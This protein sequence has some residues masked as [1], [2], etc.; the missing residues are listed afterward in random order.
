MNVL[1]L[2]SSPCRYELSGDRITS[3]GQELG[4]GSLN[5]WDG[6]W[7][8][9]E[10]MIPQQME[11]IFHNN[12]A[13][14][15]LFD[16]DGK[17]IIPRVYDSKW[18]P[19]CMITKFLLPHYGRIEQRRWIDSDVVCV[20]LSFFHSNDR[21]LPINIRWTGELSTNEEVKW[22]NGLAFLRRPTGKL[23]N[24]WRVFLLGLHNAAASKIQTGTWG[25][26]LEIEIKSSGTVLYLFWA[27]DENIKN[28][29]NRLHDVSS[30][31]EKS[32][33]RTENKWRDFFDNNIPKIEGLPGWLTKQYYHLF[34]CHKA[35]AYPPIGNFL[36][37]PFTCPSK[38]RL[39][40]QWFWD[41]AFHSIVEKWLF[42]FPE[43]K[44]SLLN[45]LESQ[46]SDGRLPFALDAH[47]YTFDRLIGKNLIQ[48]FIMPM[49]VWDIFLME[50]DAQWLRQTLPGLVAFDRWMETHRAA[51]DGAI[52]IQTAGESG[53]DN[54]VRF[55]KSGGNRNDVTDENICGMSPIDFNTF[56][57]TGRQLIAR[58]AKFLGQNELAGEFS[59]RAERM[60]KVLK[61]FWNSRQHFFS[62]RRADDV[63]NNV[64]TPAMFIPML[65]G[66]AD[67][68]QAR[69][70]VNVLTDEKHFWSRY[71]VPTLSMSDQKFSDRDEYSSY[72][73]GRTWPNVNWLIVEGLLQYGYNDVARELIRRTLE[74]VSA[75]GEPVS[76]ENYPPRESGRYELSHNIFNYGWGGL[77]NDLLLRRILGIQPRMDCGELHISPLWMDGLDEVHV[78]GLHF[79]QHMVDVNYRFNR[80]ELEIEV[81][82]QTA[83]PFIIRA[84]R[85]KKEI[86]NVTK[87][88]VQFD[89]EKQSHW[90]ATEQ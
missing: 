75:T 40:P 14:I 42:G 46:C 17:L 87:M 79:G 49:A 3:Y 7:D 53:W 58:M 57:L 76:T 32:I 38:F 62:D 67:E 47:G 88:T 66:L 21:P 4:G 9:D 2:L 45:I 84:G 30:D 43:T 16:S 72:W 33:V 5:W 19:D 36:K 77:P 78:S 28:A 41:S 23:A 89:N 54:S 85:D 48:P 11:N 22:Q 12:D 37:H 73:N 56:V 61:T 83:I 59:N 27:L 70:L 90:L 69:H 71:P 1:E 50:G 81:K 15:E 68:N 64:M 6:G 39:L 24:L 29:E 52:T 86:T 18:R 82:N 20:Q 35:N 60:A 8:N 31:T 55:L 63:L 25:A 34:Y 51:P 13:A 44:G 74:M 26:K 65:A 80:T 10:F